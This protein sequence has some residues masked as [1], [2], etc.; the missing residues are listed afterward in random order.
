MKISEKNLLECAKLLD[1]E[2]FKTQYTEYIEKYDSPDICLISEL[3]KHYPSVESNENITNEI[4]EI[5]RK[6]E[7]KIIEFIDLIIKDAFSFEHQIIK[8]KHDEIIK[9][10]KL[11]KMIGYEYADVTDGNNIIH[12]QSAGLNVEGMK[13]ILL[14]DVEINIHNNNGHNPLD[15]LFLDNFPAYSSKNASLLKK[16]IAELLILRVD[17]YDFK[18]DYNLLIQTLDFQL[19]DR[20]ILNLDDVNL[21]IKLFKLNPLLVRLNI[22]KYQ[23]WM[24]DNKK[25]FNNKS[26]MQLE[27]L[28]KLY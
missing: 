10:N 28:K 9:F 3:F 7:K 23:S 16:E 15:I 5:R 22:S 1:I 11:Y 8:R 6:N 13:I 18:E 14:D 4:I 21:I 24:F 17:G 26:F 19:R 12:M 25:N 27:E 20:K 2:S